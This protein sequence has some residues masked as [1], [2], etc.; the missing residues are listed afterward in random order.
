MATNIRRLGHERDAADAAMRAATRRWLDCDIAHF[1][2]DPRECRRSEVAL[3]IGVMMFTLVAGAA[4]IGSCARRGR[5]TGHGQGG[6][7]RRSSCRVCQRGGRRRG[8]ARRRSLVRRLPRPERRQRQQGRAPSRRPASRVPLPRAAGL[9][10]GRA[11][12]YRDGRRRQVPERRRAGQGGRLL[13]EPRT[14]AARACRAGAKPAPAKP[15]PVQAGKAAAAAC[16]GCHGDTGISKTP[17]MPSLVGLDPK[18]LVAAMNAYKSGQR[19]HDAM[20]AV[21]SAATDADIADM[22]LFYALQKPARAQTPAP[23]DQ[24]AGKAAATA[25][26]GM[27]RQQRRQR[28]S[29][30]TQPRRPGC[31]VP[32]GGASR[33]QG[34]IAQRRDDEGAGVVARRAA[35]RNLAAFYANQQPQQPKVQPA[36]DDRRVGAAVRPL[37]RR[38]RQQHRSAHAGAGRRSAPTIWKRCCMPIGR[39]SARARRWPPCRAC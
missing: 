6:R 11:R 9:P 8:Q 38:R 31:A 30:D 20:K 29:G 35:G 3:A 21:L 4:S 39:A 27:P 18:Y 19:K 25:C 23:G 36:A 28:R 2:E 32:R 37:S 1:R 26:A 33:L 5:P 16:A 15:D 14:G 34:R 12:R 17:G 22:A 13:C 24:A 10:V 7:R